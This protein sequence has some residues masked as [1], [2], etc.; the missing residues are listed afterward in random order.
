LVRLANRAEQPPKL[1]TI[2]VNKRA[3]AIDTKRLGVWL[4]RFEKRVVGGLRFEKAGEDTHSKV[5][6]WRVKKVAGSDSNLRGENGNQLV[7]AISTDIG[8]NA[9]RNYPHYPQTDLDSDIEEF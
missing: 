6:Y 5:A 9:T 1:H 8:Q 4:K 3:D 7:N 2:A